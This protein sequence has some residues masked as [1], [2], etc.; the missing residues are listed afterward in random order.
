[1]VPHVQ[2]KPCTRQSRGRVGQGDAAKRI[3]VQKYLDFA[4][5]MSCMFLVLEETAVSQGFLLLYTV[6]GIRYTF[7]QGIGS[8]SMPSVVPNFG[9]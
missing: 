2:A 3:R 5:G 4:G 7:L 9:S 1:M 6:Y 8:G